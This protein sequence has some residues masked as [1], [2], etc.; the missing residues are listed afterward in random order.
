MVAAWLPIA[1]LDVSLS[2]LIIGAL[3]LNLAI[4]AVHV[5]N[6]SMILVVRP[7]ARS[8]LVGGYMVFYSIGSAIGSIASTMVYAQAGW[9]GVCTL[10]AA[11]STTALLFWATTRHL[12]PARPEVGN[13]A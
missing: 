12:T 6:Q 7:E 2:A 10:G 5:T 9:F 1:F 8:R 11:I 13:V 3:M 4:Q